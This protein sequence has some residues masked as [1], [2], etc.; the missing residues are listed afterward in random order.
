MA[1][2]INNVNYDLAQYRRPTNDRT[3]PIN[4]NNFTNIAGGDYLGDQ[5]TV[6]DS[7][8]EYKMEDSIEK[9]GNNLFTCIH[10]IE[11]NNIES[12]IDGAKTNPIPSDILMKDY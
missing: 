1:L 9:R 6:V 10:S 8:I 5:I 7:T 4:P 3:P 2:D 11:F 12:E